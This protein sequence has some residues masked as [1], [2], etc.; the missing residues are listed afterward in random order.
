[1]DSK[2]RRLA[3]LGSMAIILLISILVVYG[4]TDHDSGNGAAVETVQSSVESQEQYTNYAGGQIGDNL[5]AFLEDE[6]FFDPEVNPILEAAKDQENRLSLMVTSVEKDLRI[7]IVNN[8]GIPVTG[9]SFYVSLR[10][11]GEYKDLDKDGVI[12]IGDLDAGE[13][14]LEL[15]PIEGY[16]VPNNETRVHVKDKVEYVAIDDIS[17]LIKT[18]AEIDA[19]AEDTA[20]AEAAADA[21]KTEIK[22]FQATSGNAHIGID[23]SKWNKEID[24]DKVKNAG[25]E[26]AII[27]AG[28]RGSVT[29]S[30]VVDPCFEANMKGAASSGIPVGVYFFTQ[31]VNEV[32]A[33]EEA[34]AVV[35]LI[36][37]YDIS[38]P[39]FIDTEGAGG[40]GRADGL[41]P[42][43][44]TLVCEAFCRTIEN[45]GYNAGVYASRNW[46]NNNLYTDRLDNYCI[47]LA[48]YRS[49]PLYQ[50]YYQMWQY[51]S[52]GA[53]D[54]IEGNVDMN[55]SY[56]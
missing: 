3:I 12:Y 30:L 15:L 20:V 13:Y 32:E 33:V 34:S 6:T 26:F 11:M 42:E 36:R 27:R 45:A 37:K 40:S 8:E 16:R 56:F 53:V 51:T 22:S 44:R 55:I 52:K 28:Y 19:E 50:G 9:E 49:T 29:G 21:D 5:S 41:D 23:V 10:D 43:T 35:E 31:A 47:W 24:W 17:L 18:E 46:Y 48:E 4:N 25:I 54:G 7:Q 38:Y 2:L 14:Y 1:M 39:I